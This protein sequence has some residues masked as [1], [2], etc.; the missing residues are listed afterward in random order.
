MVDNGGYVKHAE[1]VAAP[2]V[3][4]DRV[5]PGRF[6]VAQR[7]LALPSLPKI[8]ELG[9]IQHARVYDSWGCAQVRP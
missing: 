9:A 4:Y 6:W 7:C 1:I 3:G 2:C 5:I 8:Q